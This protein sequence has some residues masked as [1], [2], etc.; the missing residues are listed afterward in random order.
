[1]FTKEDLQDR[2]INNSNDLF[3]NI[4]L[5]FMNNFYKTF[6]MKFT[7][8]AKSGVKKL[9]VLVS[10]YQI[11]KNE[12]LSPSTFL[13]VGAGILPTWFNFSEFLNSNPWIEL[14]IVTTLRKAR[15]SPYRWET[16]IIYETAC[17]SSMKNRKK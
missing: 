2:L 10:L 9:S 6:I 7:S 16:F 15:P 14:F 11:Q 8:R 17:R 12:F 13:W 5:E 4:L 3:I 1:M